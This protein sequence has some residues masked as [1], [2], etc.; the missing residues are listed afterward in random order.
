[1]PENDSSPLPVYLFFHGGGFLF[2]TLSSEDASCGRIVAA[3]NIVVVNVCYRHTPHYK[4]P[5]QAS[6]A[7]DAFQWVRSHFDT[8]G[9]DRNRLIVGGVSAGGSL[10]SSVVLRE[11]KT[12]LGSGEKGIKGQVLCIP[13]LLL[14]GTLPVHLLASEEVGSYSQYIDAPVIPRTQLDLFASILDVKDPKDTSFFVGNCAEEDVM[15]MPKSAII[16]AG[17]DP[18]RDEGLLYADKLLKNG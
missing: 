10:A 13:Q 4:H 3:L 18:L 7:W 8:I 14:P 1:M 17:M 2:G 6:D 9:G 5:T 16:V 11:N 12:S 15:G